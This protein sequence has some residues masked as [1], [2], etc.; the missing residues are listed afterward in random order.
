MEWITHPDLSDLALE[1]EQEN[2]KK[3]G[4]CLCCG[5]MT[6]RVWGYAYRAKKPLAAYFV[7]WTPGHAYR[8]A[9]FDLIIGR[10]GEGEV[11]G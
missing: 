1:I 3:F 7:E 9:I 2:E 10:W 4:P 11:G 5:N 6:T 8:E